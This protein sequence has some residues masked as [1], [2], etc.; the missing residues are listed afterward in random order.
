MQWAESSSS[1]SLLTTGLMSSRSRKRKKKSVDFPDALRFWPA[2]VSVSLTFLSI[3]DYLLGW[4]ANQALRPAINC[5][6]PAGQLGKCREF[7]AINHGVNRDAGFRLSGKPWMELCTKPWCGFCLVW[8]WSKTQKSNM[9]PLL[10]VGLKQR[11][12]KWQQSK[13]FL[14][15]NFVN[16]NYAL[17]YRVTWCNDVVTD[18]KSL[19]VSLFFWVAVT[20][21]TG[22]NTLPFSPT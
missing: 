12:A 5:T 16:L 4:I 6:S 7:V 13:L 21:H 8:S 3:A 10:Q 11:N 20:A 15:Q 18:M 17:Y 19:S 14:N 9:G 22:I 1:S 2:V